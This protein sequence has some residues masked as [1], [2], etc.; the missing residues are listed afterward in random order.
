MHWELYRILL[1]GLY[2]TTARAKT[3]SRQS[4]VNRPRTSIVLVFL[5][6]PLAFQLHELGDTLRCLVQEHRNA[7]SP[8]CKRAMNILNTT[9]G[10]DEIRALKQYSMQCEEAPGIGRTGRM[11][12]MGSL[13]SAGQRTSRRLTSLMFDL[14]AAILLERDSRSL[15]QHND[16]IPSVHNNNRR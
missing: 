16:G 15:F 6:H 7:S 12:G 10:K 3:Q 8:R 14:M 11:L 4:Y 9:Y 5:F 2:S 13:F 1:Y